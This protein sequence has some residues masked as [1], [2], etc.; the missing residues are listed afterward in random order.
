MY[1][2]WMMKTHPEEYEQLMNLFD[3]HKKGAA[4]KLTVLEVRAL[5]NS[6]LKKGRELEEKTGLKLFPKSWNYVIV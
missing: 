2:R 4:P 6:W 1:S 5:Y 3:K